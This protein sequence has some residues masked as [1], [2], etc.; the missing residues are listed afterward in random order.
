MDKKHDQFS[1]SPL[2]RRLREMR[3]EQDVLGLIGE[4]GNPAQ[5]NGI[6]VRG[7]AAGY[8]GQVGGAE[9]VKPI[10]NLLN[11][12]E[13]DVR[14]A[15]AQALGQ[16][17]D[18]AAVDALIKALSDP[19]EWVRAVAIGSLG[20]LGDPSAVPFLLPFLEEGSW[21]WARAPTLYALLL[22]DDPAA[23][24]AAQRHLSDVPWY[25]RLGLRQDLRKHRRFVKRRERGRQPTR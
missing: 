18:A 2:F 12:G 5:A 17:G 9:A 3:R 10:T 4:L 13:E 25:L 20:Q 19:S 15:A 24:V 8:L 1:L 6:S 16:L 22:I 7:R 23:R 21:M 14:I 11:D